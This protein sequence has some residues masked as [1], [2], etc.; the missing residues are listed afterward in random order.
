MA[1]VPKFGGRVISV[2]QHASRFT[3]FM[4][5]ETRLASPPITLLSRHHSNTQLS[6]SEI[7]KAI[8]EGYH[9]TFIIDEKMPPKKKRGSEK[10]TKDDFIVEES[11]SEPEPK[12]S[13]TAKNPK[14][15]SK[16]TPVVPSGK[17]LVDEEGNDYWEVCLPF[18]PAEARDEMF[19]TCRQLGGRLRRVTLSEFKGKTLINIREHYEKD[20]KVLPG[21]KVPQIAVVAT[22]IPL[23]DLGNLSQHRTVFCPPFGSA[24]D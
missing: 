1:F 22:D 4:T 8:R 10:Y 3:R 18:S 2:I 17:K 11:D 12:R 9:D 13:K 6:P 23:T 7:R 20:G 16:V 5:H 15:K 14:E 19:L 21:K 24:P